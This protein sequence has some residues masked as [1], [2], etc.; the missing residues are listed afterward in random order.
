MKRRIYFVLLRLLL[1]NVLW[2]CSCVEFCFMMVFLLSKT[3][4]KDIIF[5]N[6]FMMMTNWCLYLFIYKKCFRKH[7][8]LEHLH[9]TSSFILSTMKH[10][11]IFISRFPTLVFHFKLILLYQLNLTTLYN[12]SNCFPIIQ[13]GV[14]FYSAYFALRFIFITVV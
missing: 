12:R 13:K 1:V 14:Y 3:V 7:Q 2:R 9:K 11:K 4:L 10:L 5:V 8:I 6:P